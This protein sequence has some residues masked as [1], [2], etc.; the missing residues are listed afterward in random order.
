MKYRDSIAAALAIALSTLVL[1][2]V[3]STD[4]YLQTAKAEVQGVRALTDVASGAGL[5]C[6]D[7]GLMA[8]Q[9]GTVQR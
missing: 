5:A 4:A 6:A 7:V 8:E 1:A 9:G 3:V 2:G